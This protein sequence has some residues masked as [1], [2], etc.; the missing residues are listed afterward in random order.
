[1]RQKHKSKKLPAERV[2]K[3]IRWRTRKQHSAEE[4]IRILLAGLCD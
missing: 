4:N 1:M 2:M 3:N